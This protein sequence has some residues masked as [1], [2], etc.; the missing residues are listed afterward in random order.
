MS[1]VRER[2]KEDAVKICGRF[3][4]AASWKVRSDR[5]VQIKSQLTFSHDFPKRI[6]SHFEFCQ[7]INMTFCIYSYF[8]A[9]TATLSV[10]TN[11]ANKY[12]E[13]S[14]DCD[15]AMTTAW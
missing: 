3:D 2:C 11:H 8:P 15:A 13:D 6:F 4:G 5:Q 1:N 12:P 7:Q 9:V 10:A 14:V